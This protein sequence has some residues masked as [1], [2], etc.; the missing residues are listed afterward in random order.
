MSLARCHAVLSRAAAMFVVNAACA[1]TTYGR[2]TWVCLTATSVAHHRRPH[3]LALIVVDQIA[4]WNT[5]VSYGVRAWWTA[6]VPT[7]LAM[8]YTCIVLYSIAWYYPAKL[9]RIPARWHLPLH[10]VMYTSS[11]VCGL[12]IDAHI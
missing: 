10:I 2:A 9:G 5:A 11:S 6:S 12:L 7:W 8:V 4:V 3:A 1:A